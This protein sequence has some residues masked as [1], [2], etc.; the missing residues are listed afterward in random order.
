MV[1]RTREEWGRDYEAQLAYFEMPRLDATLEEVTKKLRAAEKQLRSR[2]QQLAAFRTEPDATKSPAMRKLL[3]L[4]ARVAQVDSTVLVTGESGVGKE[5]IARMIHERSARSSREMV[6]INCGAL[7]ETLLESELFGHAKGSFTGATQDRAGLFEEASGGT[8][9]LDEIGEVTP[10]LQVRLLRALQEQEIRRV[11]ENKN[12]SID[13]RVI[14]ATNRNL[15]QEVKEGRFRQDLYYRLRVIELVVPPLRER[16]EDI[17]PL[18]RELLADAAA[19]TRSKATSFTTAAVDQLQ[20]YTWPGNVRE[21]ENALE[22]AAVMA[23][24]TRIDVADLPPEIAGAVATSWTPGDERTLAQ[25]ERDYILAMLEANAGNRKKTATQ[26][27]IAPATL[28]RK[29][30]TYGVTGDD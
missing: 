28:Y 22:R 7:P 4:V 11:G 14:A 16:R 6:A 23:R 10:A 15:A 19:R 1:C 21:L 8:L 27:A 29:L 17:L 26:L 24:G 13:T 30:A 3:E 18:A 20:R 9:F 25:V 2:R 12:R 5:R